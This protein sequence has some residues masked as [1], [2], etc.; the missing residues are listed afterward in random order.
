[1]TKFRPCIDLH[2]G[3]VKQIVGGTLSDNPTAASSLQTNFTSTHPAAYYAQLYR[4][5]DLRGG[6]VIMLGPGNEGAAKEAL[7]AW[8]GALQVGGGIRDENAKQWLDCGAE[9]VGAGFPI[10][11]ASTA[12]ALQCYTRPPLAARLGS[13]AAV[14]DH[15]LLPVPQ[16]HIFLGTPA[17]RAG[18]AG[19]RSE[20]ARHRPFVPPRRRHVACGHGQMANHHRFRDHAW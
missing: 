5:S 1:M 11:T 3:Q 20:S 15:H 12:V 7:A 2:A 14:G 19:R 10:S 4:E 18:G 8:P 6:H 17:R 13:S 16:G 9:K